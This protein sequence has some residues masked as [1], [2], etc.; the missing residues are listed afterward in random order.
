MATNNNALVGDAI[1]EEQYW[2][3]ITRRQI[4]AIYGVGCLVNE[5]QLGTRYSYKLVNHINEVLEECAKI[6]PELETIW[7]NAEKAYSDGVIG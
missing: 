7:A 3:P 6:C 4:M 2:L 5:P 1:H